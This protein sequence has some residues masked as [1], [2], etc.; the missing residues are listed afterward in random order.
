MKKT[1][2]LEKKTIKLEMDV[3]KLEKI[4][5]ITSKIHDKGGVD[6]RPDA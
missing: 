6:R 3:A 1:Y 5:R 2:V 4:V